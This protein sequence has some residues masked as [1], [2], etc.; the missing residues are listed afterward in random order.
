PNEL[1]TEYHDI[2]TPATPRTQTSN[3]INKLFNNAYVHNSINPVRHDTKKHTQE[4]EWTIDDTFSAGQPSAT[5]SNGNSPI[6]YTL[7]NP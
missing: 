2:S 5:V 3:S 7:P 4:Q 6:H 1:S